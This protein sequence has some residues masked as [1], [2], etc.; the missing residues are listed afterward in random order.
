MVS[1]VVFHFM[2]LSILPGG[3]AGSTDSDGAGHLP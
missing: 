3:D 2:L 1:A